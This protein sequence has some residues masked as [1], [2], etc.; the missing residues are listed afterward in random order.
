[1]K[2][3]LFRFT[4]KLFHIFCNLIRQDMKT[5]FLGSKYG[6]WQ[7]LK[8]T[9]NKIINVVSAG[10]GEDVSFDIELINKFNCKVVLIDP[11]PRAILHFEDII[12]NLGKRKIRDYDSNSG[13][14]LIDSYELSNIKLENFKLIK[15]ALFD[16]SEKKVKFFLPQ[17]E[18]HVSHSISNFQNNFSKDTDYIEVKTVTL[19]NVMKDAGL[20]KIDLLKLDIEGAENQVI[21]YMID[22]KI[23]PDQILVEFDELRTKTLRP[24]FDA[25]IIFI[26]LIFKKYYLVNTNNFPNFLFVNKNKEWVS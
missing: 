4:K 20:L 16:E 6:G 14:Q 21:P 22:K 24:Y 25:F 2:Q 10:V 9:S 11:T 3:I 15:K 18:N 8:P 5:D 1:M 23:F 19:D 26:R 17:N 12:K 13:Q 7:F